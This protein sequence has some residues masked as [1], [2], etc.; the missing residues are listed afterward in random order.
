MSAGDHILVKRMGGAYQHHGIDM[1]DGTV[2]HFSGEPFHRVEAKVC[3]VPMEAF[4]QGGQK[5]IVRYADN[6]DVLPVEETLRLA[7]KQMDKTGYSLFRNNCE[8]FATYCKTGKKS[9]QQVK[10]Y[11]RVGIT[12]A[13]AGLVAAETYIRIKRKDSQRRTQV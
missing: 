3:R 13:A 8:H 9:S 7:E 5:R 11:V 2:I 1:G 6:V 10:Q 4:L 12:I